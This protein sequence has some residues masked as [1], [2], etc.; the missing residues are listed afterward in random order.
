MNDYKKDFLEQEGAPETAEEFIQPLREDYAPPDLTDY[1]SAPPDAEIHEG[2]ST[3]PYIKRK[4]SKIFHKLLLQIAAAVMT[5][6]IAADA[7]NVDLLKRDIF[8]DPSRASIETMDLTEPAEPSRPDSPTAPAV[9]SSPAETQP[10]PPETTGIPAQTTT[11]KS[12]SLPPETTAVPP[13]TTTAGT[14]SVPA[15]T[16]SQ[17]VSRQYGENAYI[18]IDVTDGESFFFFFASEERETRLPDVDGFVFD[19][20]QNS[21]RLDGILRPDWFISI[22]EMGDDFRVQINGENRLGA[23]FIIGCSLRLGG[24]GSLLLNAPYEHVD[25]YDGQ[26][27]KTQNINGIAL[28]PHGASDALYVENGPVIDVYGNILAGI[29]SPAVSYIANDPDQPLAL[30]ILCEEYSGGTPGIV[31]GTSDGEYI[32]TFLTEDGSPSTHVILGGQLQYDDSFPELV[33]PLPP[34]GGTDEVWTRE[35]YRESG[36]EYLL[37]GFSEKMCLHVGPDRTAQFPEITDLSEYGAVYDEESNTLILNDFEPYGTQWGLEANLMGNSFTIEVHGTCHLAYIHIYG[38]YYGGSLT[39]TGDG[40]LTVNGEQVNS[41][42]IYLEAE[43]SPS[44]LMVDREVTLDVYGNPEIENGPA[45]YIYATT[46]PD[47]IYLLRP[48][49]MDGG[50]KETL[51]QAELSMGTVYVF[52]IM[53]ED[54]TYA[55]HVTFSPDGILKAE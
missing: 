48:Q 6:V 37:I 8:N 13:Q 15:E 44:C 39:I 42:G 35:A 30:H 9:P 25:S 29:N 55:T 50:A 51:Q 41:Y 10:V 28:I 21:L 31:P 17:P 3:A 16:S 45:V 33:N 34:R 38:W 19:P 11:A 23:F 54:G 12:E 14:E 53:N 26:T 5:V 46:D 36:T 22:N 49:V 20:E 40:T 4:S 2:I 43:Y 32:H 24:S 47:G 27:Y 52:G 1:P 7:V 18:Y